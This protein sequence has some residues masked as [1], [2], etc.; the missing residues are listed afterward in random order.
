VLPDELVALAGTGARTLVAAMTTDAWHTARAGF[1]RLFG[2]A[3]EPPQRVEVQLDGNAALVAQAADPVGLRQGLA[4]IWQAE[5][6]SLLRSHPE[7]ADELG[8]LLAEVRAELP[9]SLQSFVQTNVAR[10]GGTV[11]AVQGGNMVVHDS[12]GRAARAPHDDDDAL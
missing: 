10:D 9:R 1:L 6:E 2:R 12:D 8:A 5:I 3:E 4:A 7:V 11:F